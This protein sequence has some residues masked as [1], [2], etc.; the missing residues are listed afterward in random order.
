[1]SGSWSQKEQVLK[2]LLQI[3]TRKED[4]SS[5][6]LD[7]IIYSMSSVGIIISLNVMLKVFGSDQ[8]NIPLIIPKISSTIFLFTIALQGVA[9]ILRL[10]GYKH[11]NNI[12]KNELTIPNGIK[13]GEVSKKKA[14]KEEMEAVQDLIDQ[15]NEEPFEIVKINDNLEIYS[16]QLQASRIITFY[17]TPFIL[18]AGIVLLLIFIWITF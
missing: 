13:I 8:L 3:Y 15:S 12:I 1:M 11:F 5:R 9:S 17:I 10:V 6:G 7:V 18:C 2:E 16:D 14:Q 4:I